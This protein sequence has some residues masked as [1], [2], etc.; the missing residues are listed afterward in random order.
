M[1]T[2]KTKNLHTDLK[3]DDDEI[4]SL[5]LNGKTNGSAILV[6][7]E[8]EESETQTHGP[9]LEFLIPGD[10]RK[11]KTAAIDFPEVAANPYGGDITRVDQGSVSISTEDYALLSNAK[12][13]WNDS[14]VDFCIQWY[15]P[16]YR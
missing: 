6:V 8:D 3:V 9:V 16:T 13:C 12:S 7:D 1:S 4:S 5:V 11:I 2:M 14:L 15:V 10:P